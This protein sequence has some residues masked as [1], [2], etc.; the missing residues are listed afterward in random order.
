MKTRQIAYQIVG[1][2][3]Y[4]TLSLPF[5]FNSD[6]FISATLTKKGPVYWSE[7]GT[8]NHIWYYWALKPTH[9]ATLAS[10]KL[11]QS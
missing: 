11:K 5:R 7:R 4:R 3:S 8:D 2:G 10:S 6:I 9:F 1:I